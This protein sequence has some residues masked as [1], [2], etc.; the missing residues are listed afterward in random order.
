MRTIFIGIL[1]L[2]M[3]GC[4]DG[5]TRARKM[6]LAKRA[7]FLKDMGV[8]K[9]E[10]L[11]PNFVECPTSYYFSTTFF[12]KKSWKYNIANTEAASSFSQGTRSHS[13]DDKLSIEDLKRCFEILDQLRHGFIDHV[14][15]Q[16]FDNYDIIRLTGS[17]N[18]FHTINPQIAHIIST[19]FDRNIETGETK[20]LYSLLIPVS[21]KCEDDWKVKK[22]KGY[23]FSV[24]YKQPQGR[25]YFGNH[26]FRFGFSASQK[27][28]I[29]LDGYYEI[30]P[31]FPD[32]NLIVK[33]ERY[34]FLRE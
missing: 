33:I 27:Y 19:A 21:V 7:R 30:H 24:S 11:P 5:D 29:A 8:S 1:A 23:P 34:G 17:D 26:N 22:N 20:P 4:A 16:S 3:S 32:N 6:E 13:V 10:S 15:T 14:I 25:C 18:E 28:T 2:L 12:N 31:E 9:D